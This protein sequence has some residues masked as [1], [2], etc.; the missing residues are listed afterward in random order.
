MLK[1]KNEQ[2]IGNESIQEGRIQG[3]LV[4]LIIEEKKTADGRE[5]IS[6]L[7]KIEVLQ[8]VEGKVE[9]Q[10]V[11]VKM[12]S[13]K[14]TKEKNISQV[15]EKIQKYKE[16]FIPRVACMKPDGRG[17]MVSFWSNRTILKEQALSTKK[18]GEF[19]I[20]MNFMNPMREND[21]PEASFEGV[22]IVLNDPSTAEEVEEDGITLTG[23]LKLKM[24]SVGYKGNVSVFTMYLIAPQKVAHVKQ[25]WKKGDTVKVSKGLINCNE[26]VT[27]T[28]EEVGFGEPIVK[29]KREFIQE[30]I[31]VSGSAIGL[32][33]SLSY[34]PTELE[35]GLKE[36]I[37]DIEEQ[38]NK[39]SQ[40]SKTKT[41]ETPKNVKIDDND[42]DLGF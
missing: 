15:F 34:D 19:T 35:Q 21:N 4:E 18:D 30:L 20:E 12:F 29:T 38:K 14:Y 17:D 42:L 26:T 6:G 32:E 39:M 7:A 11:P 10:L 9:K 40:K 1:L 22:F 41:V 16:T 33:P 31:I 13:M 25:S 27:T 28:K 5:Y 24:A 23:R 37:K 2:G 8:D 36:R 3:E